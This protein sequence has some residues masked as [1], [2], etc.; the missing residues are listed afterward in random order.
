[1]FLL[2]VRARLFT[3]YPNYLSNTYLSNK[4]TKSNNSDDSVTKCEMLSYIIFLAKAIQQ[5]T[6][7]ALWT[8]S[9][10]INIFTYDFNV[11]NIYYLLY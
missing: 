10:R 2:D 7:I 11:Y 1:M 3:I 5:S 4:R 9:L 6:C 8:L